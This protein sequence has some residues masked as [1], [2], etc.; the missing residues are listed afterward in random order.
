V[1]EVS[2]AV[3]V[4]LPAY[5]VTRYIGEALDSIFR[6]TF[7]HF[8]IIVVNDGC[9]DSEALER[10]LEPYRP[11]IR[12][13]CQ[14]NA[15]IAGARNAGIR[16][17]TAPLIVNLDPDDLMEPTCLEDQVLFMQAHPQIAARYV[18]PVYFGGTNLDGA[19]WMDI[20]PSER[21]VSFRSVMA[22]RT[23][24]ANPGSILRR[25]TIMQVG[26]YDDSFVDS[27]E[28]FDLWLR[29][30]RGGE[31][32]SYT[33]A[34]LVRYR[35][36]AGSLT[37]R[38]LHYMER[39]LRVLD[40]AERTLIRTPEERGALERRRETVRY[41][42]NILQGKEAISRKDWRAARRHFELCVEQRPTAKL[43]AVLL[44]L[45]ACPSC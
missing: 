37:H 35:L 19:H 30:L 20:N 9:P 44:V 45:R 29:I 41:R 33:R 36:R 16:E 23:C 5:N 3:S 12:Y 2:P 43:K 42:L 28:D 7:Q 4:V 40:K 26:W 25:D 1:H 18:N 21:H 24:P 31:Q 11:R 13:V 39:A 6:Q 14:A 15:G 38:Q 8:E 22:G 10:V 32:I 17:A 27:W 34:P